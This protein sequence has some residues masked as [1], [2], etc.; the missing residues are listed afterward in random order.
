MEDIGA[1]RGVLLRSNFRLSTYYS[2]MANSTTSFA[3]VMHEFS[4]T[5]Y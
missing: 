2:S 5:F 1:Q 3:G 4:K